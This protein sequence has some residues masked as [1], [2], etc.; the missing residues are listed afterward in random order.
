MKTEVK[1]E[2]AIGYLNALEECIDDYGT[3]GLAVQL[4]YVLCNVHS[5][6]GPQAREVKAFIKKWIMEKRNNDYNFAT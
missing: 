2:I 4:N 6:K 3:R 5:W 1:N